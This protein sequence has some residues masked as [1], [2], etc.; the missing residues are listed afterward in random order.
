MVR[1]SAET[2]AYGDS[3]HVYITTPTVGGTI[4]D[5]IAGWSVNGRYLVDVVSAASG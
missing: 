1:A 3:D 2:S 5:P 4:E